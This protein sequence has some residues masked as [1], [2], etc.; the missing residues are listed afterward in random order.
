[1]STPLIQRQIQKQVQK[2]VD[3]VKEALTLVRL[4]LDKLESSL[5]TVKHPDTCTICQDNSTQANIRTNCDHFFH[6]TCLI[7]WIAYSK[8]EMMCP[9]CKSVIENLVFVNLSNCS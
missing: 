1:M 2:D 6:N 7:P 4:R 8:P 5:R 9:V 3:S